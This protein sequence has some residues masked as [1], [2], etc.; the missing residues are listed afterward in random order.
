MHTLTGLHWIVGSLTTSRPHLHL[1]P[2]P[3][4]T[5][6]AHPHWPSL[7]RWE[8]HHLPP[9][10]AP[11]P[12]TPPYTSRTPSLAFTGSLG[13]SPP[14]IL[15]TS[16]PNPA[17]HLTNTLALLARRPCTKMAGAWRWCCAATCTTSSWAGGPC[18]G[19]PAWTQQA[20]WCSTRWVWGAP[21]R[22][23]LGLDVP[24]C[25]VL[26]RAPCAG[27]PAWTPWALWC[28]TRWV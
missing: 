7:D 23:S 13:A 11:Q 27:W 17:P 25:A 26:C 19:W 2:K 1:N 3:R 4:P 16:N 24:W 21:R 22:A 18:A 28:S 9:S 5:P 8:P 6:H 14:P 10:P 20:L 15:T 12:Q